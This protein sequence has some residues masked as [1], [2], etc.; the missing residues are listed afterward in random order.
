MLFCSRK[1]SQLSRADLGKKLKEIEQKLG[2][3]PDPRDS[4]SLLMA[5]QLLDISRQLSWLSGWVIGA[6]AVAIGLLIAVA[7]T[8]F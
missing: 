8:V 7:L 3:N 5:Y 4:L 6:S 1:R 2:D